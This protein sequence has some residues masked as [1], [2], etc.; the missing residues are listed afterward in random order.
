M[1]PERNLVTVALGIV[2]WT[3]PVQTCS[4]DIWFSYL[5]MAHIFERIV[6]AA[7]MVVGAQFWFSSGDLKKM[8]DELQVVKPTIFGAVPRVMNRLGTIAMEF[9]I[10]NN[11]YII[12]DS[13]Q[14]YGQSAVT[15]EKTIR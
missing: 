14:C 12:I 3:V 2:A 11:S 4:N 13:C 6:H 7:L 8:L 9:L 10:V 15:L 5:P 1:D